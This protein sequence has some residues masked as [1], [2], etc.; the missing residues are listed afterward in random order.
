MTTGV[1]ETKSDTKADSESDA[2]SK[3]TLTIPEDLKPRDGR[4]GSGPSKVRPGQLDALAA[5]GSSLLGTSHRQ[6]PVRGLVRRVRE[7]LAD[8]FSLP[9]GYEV[10]LGN[11]GTTAFWDAAAFGLIRERSQHLAFGEFSGKFASVVSGA[12][13]LAEP[14]VVKGEP[15]TLPAAYLEEGVDAYAWPHNETSTG[16]MAPVRRVRGGVQRRRRPARAGRRDKWRR[17]PARGHP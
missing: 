7:G 11:G 2:G 9:E 5:V 12:P 4:F 17:R 3:T 6:A 10:V 1:P 16:V 8:L 14:T 13:F 15:G